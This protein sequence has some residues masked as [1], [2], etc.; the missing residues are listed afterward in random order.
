MT[1]P[2]EIR[3]KIENSI[4]YVFTRSDFTGMASYSQIG[5]VLKAMVIG[6]ELLNIG[7]GLYTKAR[8]NRIT[9]SIMPAHPGGPDGVL[10]EALDLLGVN[11]EIDNLT[12][13]YI[14]G[15]STQIPA[16]ISITLKSKKF[17]RQITVGRHRL[18]SKTD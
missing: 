8:I 15:E 7:Y 17:K 5:R 4:Q 16:K 2:V 3:T 14:D 10:I 1:I 6:G 13:K 9:G 11:Y 18:N 12:R